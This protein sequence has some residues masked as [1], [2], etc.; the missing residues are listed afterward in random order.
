MTSLVRSVWGRMH[1]V[2]GWS[3]SRP[4]VLPALLLTLVAMSQ[5]AC[6]Q[7]R[8]EMKFERVSMQYIAAL[9]GESD[10][11]GSNAQAWGLWPVDPGPRGVRLSSYEQLRSSDGRAPAGWQLDDTDWWLEEN[12]LLMEQPEFPLAPGQYHGHWWPRHNNGADHLCARCA[13]RQSLGACRW[14]HAV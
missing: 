11:S 2:F 8:G 5:V 4:T 9:G 13:G 1:R 7:E 6:A 14:C 12:G 3:T 10:S